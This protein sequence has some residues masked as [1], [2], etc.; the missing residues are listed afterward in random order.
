MIRMGR[1]RTRHKDMPPGMRQVDDRW[2]WRPTDEAARA[3][4]E[5][6]AP[7]KRGIRAG[8]NNHDKT[9]A[10]K[11]WVE[12][13][14]PAIDKAA[15]E[16]KAKP[17]TVAVILETAARELLPTYSLKQ[18]DE[19][20]RYITELRNE[21]GAMKYARSEAEASTN[22]AFLR[23]MHLTSYLYKQGQA[24][25]PV[26]ANRAVQ[27]L[28]R[29]FRI[30]KTR[31]GLTEYNP[32]LQVE[33]ND[34]VPRLVYQ[35]DTAFMK[36]YAKAPPIA[37]VLM[38]LA[39][40]AGPR[41]GMLLALNLGDV[42]DDGV[43]LT[44]N[45]KKRNA[46]VQRQLVRYVDDVGKETGLREVVDRALDL[47]RKVRGAQKA[48]ADLASAPLFLNRKGMRISETGFNSMMQRLH[49][50]A[51]FNAGEYVFHDNRRK[52]ASDAPSQ[53]KAQDLML[54]LDGRTTRGV[55]RA[56]PIEVTPLP[57]VSKG[58]S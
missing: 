48:V 21:F 38:D 18:Q 5:R 26:A 40:I 9:A 11:W 30:A 7:G 52:A 35:D 22:E 47:R 55:Y 46:P 8:E 33:Y 28:S 34:E 25:R 4:L 16:S 17:G 45:K 42:V 15:A 6:L 54:H 31:W 56:K 27:A 37:Q 53:E 2:Y 39:Q 44:R 24:G 43:W 41:R 13:I 57:R 3:V 12:T 51:G 10:R 19:W 49:R 58:K 20:G 1:P 23:S 29:M 32:C 36:V 14:L 50:R